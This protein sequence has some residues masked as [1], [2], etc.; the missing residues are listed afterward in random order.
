MFRNN[1]CLL[2]AFFGA[3]G[4]EGVGM[5][6][7]F[8]T[9]RKLIW[10]LAKNDFKKKFAGSYL[11]IVWALVQPIVTVLVYWFV[12]QGGLKPLATSEY[13][14]YPFF[15]WMLAGIVPW[16]YFQD[17]VTGGTNV[18]MEYS[19]LVKKVVFKI[20]I[21]PV[22]KAISALFIHVFFVCV[23]LVIFGCYGKF[24]GIWGIQALY[25]SF[26]MF[27]LVLGFCYASSAIAV[28]FRDLLQIV[29]IQLQV[30][31]WATPIMWNLESFG[32][33]TVL[34]T[35]FKLN[36]MYYIVYGYRDAFVYHVWFW[37]R[38]GLTLYFWGFT[39]LL[40]VLGTRIFKRLRIHFADIL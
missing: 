18:L 16:F 26:C 5:V 32:L 7:N 1:L 33:P 35:I 4:K 10:T 9:E 28:F 40:F 14:G 20:E 23:T 29:N 38:P 25:Y 30:G 11:G 39:L 19:Y 17:A 21:L 36:P 3:E 37:E 13:N 24:P 22:I 2:R 34:Q 6:K 15:L 27:A 12:F 8:V 31:I